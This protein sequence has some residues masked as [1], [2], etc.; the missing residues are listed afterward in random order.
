MGT[1]SYTAYSSPFG[2]G[3]VVWTRRALGLRIVRILLP[4]DEEAR[5]IDTGMSVHEEHAGLAALLECL[6]KF[7]RGDEVTFSLELLELDICSSFQRRVL[8]TEALVPRGRVTTYGAIARHLG[9]PGAARAV[10]RALA[11]NPF[12]LVIPCHRCVRKSGQ[13]SGYRGGLEMKRALLEMEGVPLSAGGVDR[14][15]IWSDFP[16]S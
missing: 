3:Y 10:G 14:T 15:R 16:V 11:T 8:L 1:L 9:F 6:D 5:R 7:F 13:L 2:R 12:P 4:S